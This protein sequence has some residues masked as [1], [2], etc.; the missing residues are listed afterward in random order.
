MRA[1]T[2][3]PLPGSGFE[4][5]RYEI[6]SVYPVCLRVDTRIAIISVRMAMLETVSNIREIS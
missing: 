1:Q 6:S 5:L 2:K 4:E 3:N